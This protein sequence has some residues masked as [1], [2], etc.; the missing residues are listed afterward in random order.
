MGGWVSVEF[1]THSTRALELASRQRVLVILLFIDYSTL[2][3]TADRSGQRTTRTNYDRRRCAS[4]IGVVILRLGFL[5]TIVGFA[6][7]CATRNRISVLFGC[8]LV[9][10]VIGFDCV[11]LRVCIRVGVYVCA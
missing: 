4:S 10:K 5:T 6:P 8:A 9:A 1:R 7:R 3:V 2:L 11:R